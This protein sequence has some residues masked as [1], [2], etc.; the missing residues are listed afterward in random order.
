MHLIILPGNSKQ[1][2]EQ[3][4]YDSA[5]HLKDLFESVTTH[6]YEFWKTEPSVGQADVKT[7]AEKL[8]KEASELSGEY[9]IY[10][11]SIGVNIA[12]HAIVEGG[13]SPKACIFLGSGFE[14]ADKKLINLTSQIKVP[15]LFIEQTNDPFFPY[16][17]L[18]KFLKEHWAGEYKLIETSGNNHAYDNYDEI[19]GWVKEFLQ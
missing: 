14:N 6:V 2:N 9:V 13:I 1:Y 16:A 12:I 5:K 18:E 8:I 15:T 10:A 17:D 7:E 3:G 19:K 11:K 4:L